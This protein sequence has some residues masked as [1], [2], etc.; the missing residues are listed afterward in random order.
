MSSTP[1]HFI[2]QLESVKLSVGAG[3]RAIYPKVGSTLASRT[4]Y[5]CEF[6]SRSL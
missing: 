4:N 5:S 1:I 2:Q 3:L 6:A